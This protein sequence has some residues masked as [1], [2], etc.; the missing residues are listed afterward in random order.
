MAGLIASDPSSSEECVDREPPMDGAHGV[1]CP[2]DV[3]GTRE[4]HEA[5]KVEEL[6]LTG[7]QAIALSPK[8]QHFQ[9]LTALWLGGNK[10]T[11]LKQLAHARNLQELYVQHNALRRL[12]PAVAS[13]GQLRVLIAHDNQLQDWERT[14][15]AL[16]G[17]RHRRCLQVLTLYGNPMLEGV[18]GRRHRSAQ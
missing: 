3:L 8:F 6:V 11:C 10:L 1:L 7:R 14:A 18:D 4:R 15:A 5:R 12:C 17:A 13:L 16:A 2:T 9:N